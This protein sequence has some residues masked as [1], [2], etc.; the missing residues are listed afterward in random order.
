MILST[1]IIITLN[2]LIP[3]DKH[4]SYTLFSVINNI[5]DKTLPLG[6]LR[7]LRATM[8]IAACMES[9]VGSIIVLG[10]SKL[11]PTLNL[12]DA[13]TFITM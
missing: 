2:Y 1:N 8:L 6:T 4:Y 5:L 13:C 11:T 3:L 10:I 7:M 9:S 12:Q